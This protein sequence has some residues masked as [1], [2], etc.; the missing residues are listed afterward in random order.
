MIILSLAADNGSQLAGCTCEY[1]RRR[2]PG[3]RPRPPLNIN[4]LCVKLVNILYEDVQP[5]KIAFKTY[6]CTIADVKSA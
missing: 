1:W 4:A 5:M 2:R 3:L 6:E